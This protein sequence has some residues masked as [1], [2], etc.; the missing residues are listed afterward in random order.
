M[1]RE[2]M[3]GWQARLRGN[4][5]WKGAHVPKYYNPS[6]MNK[7]LM[8]YG[9]DQARAS[10]FCVIVEGPTDVW[11]VGSGAVALLGKSMSQQQFDLIRTHWRAAVVMLDDDAEQAADKVCNQLREAM[12]VVKVSLPSGSDPASIGSQD[13]LWDLIEA[14]V[15][16]QGVDLPVEAEQPCP[17]INEETSG[18][19]G[20]T[21]TPMSP[22]VYIWM[23]PN[24]P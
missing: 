8:L 13:A 20:P 23:E 24:L 1:M 5:E 22:L 7:R 9:F 15:V 10:P 14:A 6:G 12:P 2:A 4:L 3:V 19:P 16:E 11:A 17:T 18:R 21:E